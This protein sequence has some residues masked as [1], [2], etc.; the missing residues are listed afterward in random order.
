MKNYEKN[1]LINQILVTSSTLSSSKIIKKFKFKKTIHQFYPVDHF[2]FTNK[3][4]N[5]WKPNKLAIFIESEIWPCMFKNLKKK[6]FHYFIKCKT[7]KKTFNKW[8]KIKKFF[9]KYFKKLLKLFHKM[10]K[11]KFFKK[12]KF[13]KIIN[14]IG[15]L[16]F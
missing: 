15:N 10:M 7:Y 1:K 4:L 16:K 11:Q 12:I 14:H 5:Y 13:N 2:F 8:M 6:I 9:T 3:F